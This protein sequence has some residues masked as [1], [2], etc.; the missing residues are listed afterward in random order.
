M[1]TARTTLNLP[2]DLIREVQKLFA[3]KTKTETIVLALQELK[4]RKELQGLLKK[5]GGSGID[6]TQAQ[7]KKMR[8]PRITQKDFE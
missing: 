6:L 2:I 8:Q 7:L 4:K 1:H 5:L 3:L